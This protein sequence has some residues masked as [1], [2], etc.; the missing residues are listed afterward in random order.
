MP[1]LDNFV[2]YFCDEISDIS[3]VAN[4]ESLGHLSFEKNPAIKDISPLLKFPLD[5][6]TSI[7]VVADLDLQLRELFNRPAV[8]EMSFLYFGGITS[9]TT[10]RKIRLSYELNDLT[11]I[12]SPAMKDLR[13]LIEDREKSEL[14]SLTLKGCINLQ[15]ISQLK[16]LKIGKLEIADCPMISESQITEVSKK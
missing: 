16:Q 2:I 9:T 3:P 14:N 10:L 8:R 7:C 6:L 12:D 11:I 4:M 13:F 1:N 5:Q 15:D